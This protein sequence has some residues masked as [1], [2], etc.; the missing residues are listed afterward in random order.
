MLKEGI[1]TLKDER[2]TL[3]NRSGLFLLTL[4]PVM[5]VIPPANAQRRYA[6]RFLD[7]SQPLLL[8]THGDASANARDTQGTH[9][10][11][12]TVPN[13]TILPV[14]LSTSLSSARSRPGQVVT[15]RIMQDVPLPNGE[16]IRAGSKIEGHVVE[17]NS[18]T[19]AT[20]PTISV[21]F[22]KLHTS[23]GTIPVT[24]SL[25]AIA[26]PEEVIEAQEP[27]VGPGEGDV[28]DWMPTTLVGGDVVYGVGGPVTTGDNPDQV[29]GSGVS[30]GVLSQVRAREGTKCRGA[31]D[32]NDSPQALWVFSSDACGSYRLHHARLVHAGRTA[33]VGLVVLASEGGEVKLPA[34]TGM[35][36]RVRGRGNS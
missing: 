36:L 19:G 23:G 15:G 16:K 4:L 29:V 3:G 27:E 24:T 21:Q 17:V 12:I 28:W 31:M 34:G 25:R 13:G 22:D 11:S 6:W 5:L 35:L 20:G 26:G 33:P 30:G 18:R 2:R 14:S 10:A 9:N 1:M 32:G 7:A 8:R